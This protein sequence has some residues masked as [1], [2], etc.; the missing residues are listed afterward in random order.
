MAA[1]TIEVDGKK[2]LAVS[3]KNTKGW[4]TYW[5][6]PGDAGLEVKLKFKLDGKDIKLKDY[7]WPAPKRYIEQGEMWAYGYSGKYAQ[8]FDLDD[9]FKSKTLNI[10]GQWLVCS[11]ICIPG[12]RT[13]DLKLDHYLHG[14]SNKILGADELR[15]R[16]KRLP[17]VGDAPYIEIF[18]TKGQKENQLALHYLIENADFSKINKK[19]SILTPYLQP[20]FDYKH[21]EVFLDDT[22]NTIYGRTYL[23]WDGIYED[24]IENLPADGIFKTPITAK[25]LLQYPAG[26]N[27]KIITK[28]FKQFTLT[29]D[30]ELG[31][32][33]KS[34]TKLGDTEGKDKAKK[35]PSKS[36][37]YFLLF[38]F[39]GG[40]I[41]N[42]MPC[43]LPVISLKLFGLIVHSE[44]SKKDILKH[45]LAYTA[46]V[47]FSFIVL[48][49][50]IVGLKSSGD[51]IGWGFQL[52]SP[53]F[54]FLMLMVIFIMALNMLGL[55][56]F[57]TPG[58]KHIGNAQMKK[59][60]YADFINGILATILSTPC[61]A[62]FLGTALTFAFTTSYL[63]IFLILIFVGIGLA[64]PFILTGFFPGM[65]RLLPKPGLWMD[66]L[67]KILGLSLLLTA[68]WLVDVLFSI[69][70]FEGIGIYFNALIAMTFFAFYF[71][72]HIS[73]NLIYNIIVFALPIFLAYQVIV[74]ATSDAGLAKT[75]DTTMSNGF[76]WKRWSM[77]KMHNPDKRLRF[78][79][80]TAKWCLTCKVNKKIVLTSSDFEDLVKSKNIELLEGDWTKRDEDISKF[81]EKY[82]IY[83]VP[84]Y[85]VQKPNG[86]VISLGETISINKI[87]ENIK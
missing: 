22:T 5:K 30:K 41:L 26:E 51:A 86:E 87:K 16:F 55:F 76:M 60:V 70:D 48:A 45:N 17:E 80:F 73:K 67:K 32:N 74:F 6:N 84:A 56:E 40:I 58:G 79:N 23:D 8:Y 31:E 77:D 24:P 44:E 83:G 49:G 72:R 15:R 43:V 25:F 59:G 57:V 52:Q 82:S 20:P 1:K 37:L 62:P 47:L 14:A 7:P 3:F 38:A 39:L 12:T 66:K 4:H 71:R 13:I 75:S 78:I 68:V 9:T 2:I 10:V 42:F 36:I 63:N 18:L 53:L 33:F 19:S 81:L 21:E 65:I 50:V 28:T 85:F 11:D 35:K 61:S 27:G 34:L 69:I 54:V 29:G 64:F 46:G